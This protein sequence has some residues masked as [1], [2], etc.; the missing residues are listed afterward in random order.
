MIPLM[1]S[2]SCL[3]L[4]KSHSEIRVMLDGI[5]MSHSY[6]G[7]DDILACA[8]NLWEQ[9]AATYLNAICVTDS[10]SSR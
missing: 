10:P 7:Q 2:D 6:Y 4:A 8:F 5:S 3:R 9:C 1:Y